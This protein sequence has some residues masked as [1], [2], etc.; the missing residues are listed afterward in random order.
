[1]KPYKILIVDDEPSVCNSLGEWFLEDGFNVETA[2]SGEI[3]LQKMHG[4]TFD[5]ILLDIKMPGMDGITL[6]KK[7]REIDPNIIVIIMTAFASV[8]TAVEALKLGAFDYITKP[9]DPDD[10]SRLVRNA[11]KQKDLSDENVQLK[12][13]ITELRGMDEIVGTSDKIREVMEMVHTVAETDSTVLIRGESG[14]GKELVARAIHSHSKRRYL[15]IVAVNCGAIPETLLESELFG[16]EK[17]AFTGAQYRRKGRLEMAHGGT[18]FLD[19]IGDISPK[20]QV[21]LLRVIESK[22]FTRLGGTAEIQVDFR[23]VFATNKN[24]EKL[25]EEGLFRED[26][27]YRINVFTIVIP[28]LRERRADILPLARHFIGKY[29]RAMGRPQKSISPEAE[30]I[31]LRHPW[32]G[33]VRE[34]ENAIERAMVVGKKPAVAAEDL[35]LQVNNSNHDSGETQT[36]EELEKQHIIKVLG[37]AA[38]NVT[39]AAG[40][41]GI[42]RVT[43]YNKLK[44]YKI[45]RDK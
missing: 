4:N 24:L 12:D 14:T 29:A 5:I 42:D 23:L 40:V 39:Q 38:G 10:L 16:H 1:M 20:M 9:F 21:D 44:K 32:P 45:S 35:P 34:L 43:L 37:E 6:Q 28:P 27:Y 11:I 22:R 31:L 36:L 13:Q 2:Q 19:E 17:G 33:N 41:L 25:V 8:E 15:P 3:A 26:L 30:A 7:I 18:L